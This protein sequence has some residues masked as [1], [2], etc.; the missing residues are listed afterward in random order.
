MYYVLIRVWKTITVE[1]MID[2][3]MLR[4]RCLSLWRRRRRSRRKMWGEG[5][6]GERRKA[7]GCYCWML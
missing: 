7:A 2:D 5:R 4:R 6:R 1:G 3:T